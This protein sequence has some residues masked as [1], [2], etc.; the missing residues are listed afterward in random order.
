M[1]LCS[2]HFWVGQF[3]NRRVKKMSKR[4]PEETAERVRLL[5]SKRVQELWNGDLVVWDISVSSYH[6]VM[7]LKQ[8]EYHLDS[9]DRWMRLDPY[10][11]SELIDAKAFGLWRGQKYPAYKAVYTVDYEREFQ[12]HI[13]RFRERFERE[14]RNLGKVL[15]PG[16]WEYELQ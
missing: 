16:V 15:D 4:N 1:A 2:V 12:Y 13:A 7:Y 10:N 9:E 6:K 8:P 3:H 5:H 14:L 11:S